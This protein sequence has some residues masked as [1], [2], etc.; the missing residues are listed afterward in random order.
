MTTTDIT[1][2]TRARAAGA[3]HDHEPVQATPGFVADTWN[4]MTRE[5][6][7]M[8]R[9]PASILFDLPGRRRHSGHLREGG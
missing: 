7:P 5:L 3:D 4:V 6:K 9:E 8:L 1:P 2:T